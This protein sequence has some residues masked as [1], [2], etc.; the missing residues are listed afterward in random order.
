VFLQNYRLPLVLEKFK[1]LRNASSKFSI[2]QVVPFH[3]IELSEM[4]LLEEI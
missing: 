3:I 2:E 1:E 4:K